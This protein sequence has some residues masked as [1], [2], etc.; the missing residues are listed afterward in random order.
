[1]SSSEVAGAKA[2]L[3]STEVACAKARVFALPVGY[4]RVPSGCV[5]ANLTLC[6]LSPRCRN[7]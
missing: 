2:L 4:P 7:K 3:A 5:F 6:A 1:M